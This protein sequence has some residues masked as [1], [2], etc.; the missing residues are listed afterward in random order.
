MSC[1]PCGSH[2]I[3]TFFSADSVGEKNKDALLRK[4]QVNVLLDLKYKIIICMQLPYM[5]RISP[6]AK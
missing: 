2:V 5:H 3:D 1:D 6:Y 4:L